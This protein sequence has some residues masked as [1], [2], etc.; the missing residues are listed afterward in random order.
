MD[1]LTVQIGPCEDS[2]F[3]DGVDFL[4]TALANGRALPDVLDVDEFFRAL[5]GAGRVSAAGVG[6]RRR[7][8]SLP[9]PARRLPIFNCSCG[10]F[11]CGGYYVDV[12]LTPE[13]LIWENA[14]TNEGA[15]AEPRDRW[16]YAF[17]WHNVRE[18]AGELIAA[19]YTARAQHPNCEIRYGATG[20]EVT[21]RLSYYLECYEALPDGTGRSGAEAN[22]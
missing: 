15:R 5:K 21:E 2:L 20:V 17:P 6:V 7:S 10:C 11:G 18:V 12:T 4:V 14:Y 13:A 19:I 9:P 3:L 8:K 22:A 16:R 1:K